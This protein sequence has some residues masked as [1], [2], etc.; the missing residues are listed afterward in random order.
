MR[1]HRLPTGEAVHCYQKSIVICF[2]RKVKVLSTAHRNGGYSEELKAVFNHDATQGASPEQQFSIL[3]RMQRFGINL[4]RIWDQFKTANDLAKLEFVCH[5]EKLD[6]EPELVVLASLY[7]HLLD[8]LDWELLTMAQT[9]YEAEMILKRMNPKSTD[10]SIIEW[11][12]MT[13]DAVIEEMCLKMLACLVSLLKER[14][15]IG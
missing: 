9:A 11:E 15:C 14:V 10:A 12:G 13:K 5:L 6:R 4:D 8:Q 7:A 2:E 1:I 3:R